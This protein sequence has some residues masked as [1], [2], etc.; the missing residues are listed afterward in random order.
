MGGLAAGIPAGG[1]DVVAGLKELDERATDE[2]CTPA[3]VAQALARVACRLYELADT[4]GGVKLSKHERNTLTLHF[5][6]RFFFV[7]NAGW[8]TP[9][10]VFQPLVLYFFPRIADALLPL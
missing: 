1:G 9:L 3:G 4:L 7:R 6:F 8:T 10:R 5:S 2:A